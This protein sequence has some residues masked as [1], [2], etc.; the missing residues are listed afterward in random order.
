LALGLHVQAKKSWTTWHPSLLA[1]LQIADH[2]GHDHEEQ[3]QGLC[4]GSCL[5]VGI[6]G[7]QLDLLGGSDFDRLARGQGLRRLLL[8]VLLRTLLFSWGSLTSRM[9]KNST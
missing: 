2:A 9:Y 7:I 6:A 8:R 5:R 4:S 3:C 1:A